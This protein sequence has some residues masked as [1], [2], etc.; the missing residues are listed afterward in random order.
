MAIPVLGNGDILTPWDL[1]RRR[2][3]TRVRSFLVA[4]GALIKPWIFREL[5]AGEPWHPTVAERWAVMRRY[6]DFALRVLRR[7]REGPGPGRSAS[8]SGTCDFWHRYRPW[9]EADFQAHLPDSLIQA[10]DAAA[11][12][13]PTR[14]CWPAPTR[15]TT[16]PSGAASLTGTYPA[17]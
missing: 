2:R 5:A 10:R 7:R 14:R 17:A 3:E 1:E 4:R 11:P 15:P 12:G 6:F 8:S 9:T 13:D 16:R